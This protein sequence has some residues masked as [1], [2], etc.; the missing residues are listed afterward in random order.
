M[1][2]NKFLNL[3]NE[4]VA[5][6]TGFTGQ[7]RAYLS[8]FLLNKEDEIHMIIRRENSKYFQEL[9]ANH[10]HHHDYVFQKE[11]GKSSWI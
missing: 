3:I 4:K 1:N 11:I 8:E 7:N 5:L 6:I 9:F 2:L 10:H